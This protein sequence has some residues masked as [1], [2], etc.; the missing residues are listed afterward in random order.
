MTVQM[1]CP[2]CGISNHKARAAIVGST[3]IFS[4]HAASLPHRCTSRPRR[5]GHR[6]W[7][8]RIRG[9][10]SGPRPS[11]HSTDQG[12][13]GRTDEHHVLR[14]ADPSALIGECLAKVTASDGTVLV[15]A[16]H[17]TVQKVRR[18]AIGNQLPIDISGR[19]RWRALGEHGWGF[20]LS[21]PTIC[22]AP[23]SL[24]GRWLSAVR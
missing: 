1:T 12:R 11:A 13:Q 2:V 5:G 17:T 24:G 18:Q 19:G 10:R 21:S 23:A 8:S 16:S 9:R 4:H 7:S 22:Y 3:P 14:A 6:S 20:I 15:G